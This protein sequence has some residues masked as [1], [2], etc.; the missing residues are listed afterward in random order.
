[1]QAELKNMWKQLKVQAVAEMHSYLLLRMGGIIEIHE[2]L[3][4]H[5]RTYTIPSLTLPR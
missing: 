2:L 3:T 4:L 1:M 5:P